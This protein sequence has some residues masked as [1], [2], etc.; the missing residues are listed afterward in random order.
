MR[1]SSR[2]PVARGIVERGIGRLA[3][4]ACSTSK[5]RELVRLSSLSPVNIHVPTQGLRSAELALAETAR[6][7]SRRPLAARARVL[8]ERAHLP[9]VRFGTV[10]CNSLAPRV[11]P[12]LGVRSVARGRAPGSTTI[13]VMH[14]PP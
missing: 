9:R 12:S 7:G 2:D 3:A 1:I 6:V 11:P 4:A 5:L 8:G 13:R 14:S 10:G